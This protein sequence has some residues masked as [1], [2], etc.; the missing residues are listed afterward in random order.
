M[1]AY[2]HRPY[3]YLNV[4]YDFPFKVSQISDDQSDHSQDNDDL[5]ED[6]TQVY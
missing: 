1:P 2:P 3:P 5:Y 4:G 6:Y